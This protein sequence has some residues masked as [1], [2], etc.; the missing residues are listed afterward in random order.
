MSSAGHLSEPTPCGGRLPTLSRDSSP[1]ETTSMQDLREQSDRLRTIAEG[2]ASETGDE[3]FA[4]LVTRLTST[5]RVPYTVI[6][7]V[8]DG[9]LKKIR[10]LAV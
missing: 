4:S 2:T 3:F 8:L 10:T 1:S 9:P 7:E 6:G 5:L